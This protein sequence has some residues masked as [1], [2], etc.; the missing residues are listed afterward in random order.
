MKLDQN[1]LPRTGFP[2][3][4]DLFTVRES[5]T[6]R[7]EYPALFRMQMTALDN[8]LESAAR[9]EMASK[10]SFLFMMRFEGAVKVQDWTSLSGIIQVNPCPIFYRV[11]LIVQDAVTAPTSLRL[12]E[13]IADLILSS[14][15]PVPDD[16]AL[17][18][19]QDLLVAV[20]QIEGNNKTRHLKMDTDRI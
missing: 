3:F 6:L 1:E 13:S 14:D 19:M 18:T 2:P 5:C 7:G 11:I 17:L 20:M 4:L 8:P 9:Q 10:Y 16:T 15:E 12:F